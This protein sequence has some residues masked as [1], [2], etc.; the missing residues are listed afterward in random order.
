MQ[1]HEEHM[2]EELAYAILKDLYLDNDVSDLGVLILAAAQ[3]HVVFPEVQEH[4]INEST[5]IV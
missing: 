1:T 4:Y 3:W 2:A 5:V